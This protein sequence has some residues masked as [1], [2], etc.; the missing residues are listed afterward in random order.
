MKYCMY[1]NKAK[2]HFYLVQ[3]K[4]TFCAQLSGVNPSQKSLK[5]HFS[6]QQG[7]GSVLKVHFHFINVN[8][9]HCSRYFVYPFRIQSLEAVHKLNT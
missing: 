6:N 9:Y 7:T 8:F 5:V 1:I 2:Q 4:S 3:F